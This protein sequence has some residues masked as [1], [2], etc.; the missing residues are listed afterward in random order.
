MKTALREV[1]P[2]TNVE[3]RHYFNRAQNQISKQIAALRAAKQVRIA[4]YDPPM[5]KG[6]HSPVYALGNPDVE[7][8]VPSPPPIKKSSYLGRNK[9]ARRRDVGNRAVALPAIDVGLW[10]GLVMRHRAPSLD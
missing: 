8:D 7:P 9:V 6:R 4:K 3:L 5:G 1:G 10:G 2:M